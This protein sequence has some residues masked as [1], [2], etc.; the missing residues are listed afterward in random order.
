VSVKLMARVWSLDVPPMEQHILHALADNADDA[1]Q[2]WPSAEFVAWKTGLSERKVRA[3]R[4]EWIESGALKMVG[5]FNYATGEKRALKQGQSPTFGRGFVPVFQLDLSVF[6]AKRSWEEVRTGFQ[7]GA[8]GAPFTSGQKGA[9]GA[10]KGAND[11]HKGCKSTLPN[12]EEPSVKPSGKSGN[13]TRLSQSQLDTW[14]FRR[15][16]EAMDEIQAAS[17]GA[18][19]EDADE[20]FLSTIR[21]AAYRA[22]VTVDRAQE[23]LKQFWPADPLLDRLRV[24]APAAHA[25]GGA[26]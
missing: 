1:G 16:K 22:G 11:A 3:Q 14:D 5:T 25:A 10:E 21:R 13:Q 4:Q 7:K 15:L 6:P 26:Q 9:P 23:L 24:V 20:A 18:H 19:S 8:E 12:K 2:H 17:V